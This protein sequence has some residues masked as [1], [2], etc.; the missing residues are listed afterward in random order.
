MLFADSAVVPGWVVVDD[1]PSYVE[2]RTFARW[3]RDENVLL[4][5]SLENPSSEPSG[6]GG[7]SP[8]C[9][10]DSVRLVG[11]LSRLLSRRLT[12]AR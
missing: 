3:V 9:C 5:S 10:G 12:W 2:A 7:F 6:Q 1:R 4:A 11:F 8:V